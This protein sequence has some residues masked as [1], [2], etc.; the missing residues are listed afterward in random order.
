MKNWDGEWK[1]V[2]CLVDNL[3]LV[4]IWDFELNY[5]CKRSKFRSRIGVLEDGLG[6]KLNS[7][8]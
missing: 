4:L 8:K 7:K 1:I 2:M 5:Y 3:E 6:L